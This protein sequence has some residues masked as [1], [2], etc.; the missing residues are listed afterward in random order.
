MYE[1]CVSGNK[2]GDF[3]A[4]TQGDDGLTATLSGTSRS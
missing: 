3:C 1:S 2:T 4:N